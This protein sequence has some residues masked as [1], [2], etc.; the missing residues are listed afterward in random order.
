MRKPPISCGERS[1]PTFPAVGRVC[2]ASS[3][4]SPW[5]TWREAPYCTPLPQRSDS[6]KTPARL[7]HLP[8]TTTPPKHPHQRATWTATTCSRLWKGWI[9]CAWWPPTRPRPKPCAADLWPAGCARR[10]RV[11]TLVRPRHRGVP[12]VRRPPGRRHAQAKGVGAPEKAPTPRIRTE[13]RP[14]PAPCRPGRA[15]PEEARPSRVFGSGILEPA[16]PTTCDLHACAAGGV[17][18]PPAH[19]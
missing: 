5:A 15:C 11:R 14:R 9:H 19:A 10:T 2:G 17:R 18:R 7:S 12:S 6:A 8:P 16:R 3:A 13:A 4:R 1:M